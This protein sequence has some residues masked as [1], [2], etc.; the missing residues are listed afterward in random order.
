MT[1]AEL[2]EQARETDQGA[3]QD[4]E[5][6]V[7]RKFNPWKREQEFPLGSK[8]ELNLKEWPHMAEWGVVGAMTVLAYGW[9]SD[10][11]GHLYR[12]IDEKGVTWELDPGDLVKGET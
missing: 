3:R 10:H 6:W 1:S 11:C 4:L 7:G 9:D 8:V 2:A 5:D 12:L